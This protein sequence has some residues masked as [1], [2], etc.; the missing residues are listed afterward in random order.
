MYHDCARYAFLPAST[1]QHSGRY[2]C[3]PSTTSTLLL[4]DQLVVM[5]CSVRYGSVQAQLVRYPVDLAVCLLQGPV[6]VVARL[7]P[8]QVASCCVA[9]LLST[10]SDDG[11]ANSTL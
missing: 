8:A 2:S 6:C 7:Q 4:I 1:E 10:S 9:A 5:L 11:G 3:Q